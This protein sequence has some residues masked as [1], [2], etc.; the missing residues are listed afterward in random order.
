MNIDRRW[1]AHLWLH[2]CVQNL[3]W[4]SFQCPRTSSFPIIL[5]GRRITLSAVVHFPITSSST[6]R[7]SRYFFPRTEAQRPLPPSFYFV[8]I[9]SVGKNNNVRSSQLCSLSSLSGLL[10][11][12]NVPF[13]PP[14][15]L[16]STPG[17]CALSNFLS[18][19]LVSYR[20]SQDAL[21]VTCKNMD[22]T[23]PTYALAVRRNRGAL[24]DQITGDTRH[25]PS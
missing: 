12:H 16:K 13:L 22:Y 17:P 4:L 25:F 8:K 24:G 5:G 14:S 19:A 18:H 21:F 7:R 3:P 15:A 9:K 10:L 2:I 1:R 11:P 20:R 23:F 6:Q